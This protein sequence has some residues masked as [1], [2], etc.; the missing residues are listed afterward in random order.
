MSAKRRSFTA[1]EKVE[2]IRRHLVEGVPVS[3]L[4]E[5]YQ[6]NVNLFYRWQKQF[7]E[8]GALALERKTSSVRQRDPQQRKIQHLEKQVQ[9]KNE[10]IAELLQEHVQLKKSNG[11]V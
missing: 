3:D 11:G 8:N 4:C 6:V 1:R 5:E 9:D 7:F 2:L 10:V